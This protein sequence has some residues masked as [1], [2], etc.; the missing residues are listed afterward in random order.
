VHHAQAPCAFKRVVS[1]LVASEEERE[2][3]LIAHAYLHVCGH[4]CLP[5]LPSYCGYFS[6]NYVDPITHASSHS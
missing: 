3:D 1:E 5:A 2:H 6:T 4:E